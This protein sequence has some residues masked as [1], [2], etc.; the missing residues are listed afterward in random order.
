MA[1]ESLKLN[2]Q[3]LTNPFIGATATSNGQRGQHQH[4]IAPEA[5]TRCD[6]VSASD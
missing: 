6:A 4:R 3:A 2:L 5:P 1:D